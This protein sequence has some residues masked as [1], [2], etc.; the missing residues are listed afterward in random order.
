MAAEP[1]P[2]LDDTTGGRHHRRRSAVPLR[3]WVDAGRLMTAVAAV[4]VVAT[5]AAGVV[6]AASPRRG[7][8]SLL[9]P[10]SGPTGAG[11]VSTTFTP[12][13][14]DRPGESVGA[15]PTP[16]QSGAASS[17]TATATATATDA[18]TAGGTAGPAAPPAPVP[19]APAS[20]PA[21]RP[22]AP[23]S[24]RAAGYEAEGPAGSRSAG[25]RFRRV[26]AASGGYVVGYLGRGRSLR[27]TTVRVPTAGR[28]RLT[29]Y[30][31]AGDPRAGTIVVNGRF[32]G[33]S[34]FPLTPDWYTVGSVTVPVTLAGG[35]NTIEI[36]NERDYAPD[37]DRIL[38]R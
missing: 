20:A 17:A 28:Y 23:A 25:T 19:D 29:V 27:F 9:L 8:R 35:D 2:Q 7:G 10:A 15:Y 32:A 14:G 36:G 26:A 18:A 22:A 34:R 21:P 24:V 13:F 1:A 33:S 37:V 6:Q 31:I 16:D 30:Y 5:I 38:V 4:L 3:E 11:E 12:E